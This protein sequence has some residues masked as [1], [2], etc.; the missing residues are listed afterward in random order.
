V[1]TITIGW[2]KLSAPVDSFTLTAADIA[3]LFNLEPDEH[4]RLDFTQIVHIDPVAY[5][6][7][8][9]YWMVAD[10]D[11]VDLDDWITEA[12]P[13]IGSD[14][15]IA[16]KQMAAI[17]VTESVGAVSSDIE[18]LRSLTFVQHSALGG[19]GEIAITCLYTKMPGPM[20]YANYE[21]IGKVKQVEVE[22]HAG[23]LYFQTNTNLYRQ[24]GP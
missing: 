13:T 24:V 18:P 4:I 23:G 17:K 19:G 20:D 8:N 7:A 3:R 5:D 10:T 16:F 12:N 1:P 11:R 14:N 22:R 21:D 6:D 2:R 9:L 15:I